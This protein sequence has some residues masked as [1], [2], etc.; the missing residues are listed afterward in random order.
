MKNSWLVFYV[1]FIL[2]FTLLFYF[3]CEVQEPIRIYY[4]QILNDI[5]QFSDWA[6]RKS[7]TIE[8]VQTKYD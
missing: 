5:H 1:L 7:N 8:I 6:K 2:L 4:G 3:D